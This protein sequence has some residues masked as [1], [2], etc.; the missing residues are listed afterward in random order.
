[1]DGNPPTQKQIA[2]KYDGNLGYFGKSHYLRRLRGWCFAIVALCSLVGAITFHFW[3]SGKI[4]SK[5][6]ISENHAGFANDCRACHIDAETDAL[7]ALLSERPSGS[8]LRTIF[9][10]GPSHEGVKNGQSPAA[11]SHMDQACLKCHAAYG[12]HLPQAAGLALRTVSND[13]TVV[14]A[15]RCFVCHRE[16]AGHERM[17]LPNRQTCASCHNDADELRRART[18]FPLKSASVAATG[19]KTG[20]N[21]D[22]GDGLVRFLAPA[23]SSGSVTPFSD[24]AHGHP[25]FG[26]EQPNLRDP[27]QLKFNHARHERADVAALGPNQKLGC[28][29]CHETGPGGVYYQPVRYER[30]CQQCHSL[31]IQPSLPRL[32][33]PHGDPEKVRYFL[34]SLKIS[35]E[36]AVRAEGVTDPAEFSRRSESE[37]QR[38]RQRGLDTL[39]DLEKRV[40]FEGDPQDTENVRR[41]RTGSR[42]FLT[43]CANCHTVAPG[44]ASSPPRVNRPNIAERWI[45]RGPFTHLRHLHI[46]CADCHQAAHTSKLTSDIL[47][48]PQKLCA[49][50]H[51]P[52]DT[53][54]LDRHGDG[55]APHLVSMPDGGK[56]AAEQRRTGGIKW[57]CLSCHTF[58]APPDAGSLTRQISPSSTPPHGVPVA[59]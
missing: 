56:L 55:L 24:Y 29:N 20:E 17:A 34:A 3:G 9:A 31:Q 54:S 8:S 25:P 58:H 12:L 42:K 38:L 49:E 32:S 59:R 37:L 48:P 21:R 44:D 5:G 28:A 35:I 1:M 41:M 27:A 53:A 2:Q 6:P 52:P 14:H 7:K 19:E 22:L 47:M 33:I 23:R 45:Q 50:C 57:D 43:E 46:A 10:T 36:N 30:H 51:R 4:F 39:A 18:S 11:W 26:Y 15:T 16:H 40:F 13:L